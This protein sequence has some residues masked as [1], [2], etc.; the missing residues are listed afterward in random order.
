M[1]FIHS[2]DVAWHEGE[3]KMQSLLRVPYQDNPTSPFLTP[4]AAHMLQ[5]SPLL[6]VGILDSFGRPWTTIWGGAPGFARSL[7]S[8]IIGVKVSVDLTYDPVVKV[9]V[10]GKAE[11][12]VVSSGDG[13]RLVSGL[14]INL[15]ARKRVKI[16]GRIAAVAF[17]LAKPESDLQNKR[18]KVGE[19]QLV[20]KVEESLGMLESDMIDQHTH[21]S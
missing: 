16:A 14:A 5:V 2:K 1:A 13:G 6:A 21:L 17:D 12:E 10:D 15:N 8:S 7:G 19:L 11:G 18:S 4:G 9:L 3:A 20:V